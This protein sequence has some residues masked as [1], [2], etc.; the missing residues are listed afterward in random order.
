[1]PYA[2]ALWH[3]VRRRVSLYEALA[4]QIIGLIGESLI[5]WGLGDGHPIAAGTVLRFIAFDAAGVILL[6]IAA[7]VT[8]RAN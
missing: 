8:R 5:R 7:G 2:V 1:M 4:M 3:P 6:A